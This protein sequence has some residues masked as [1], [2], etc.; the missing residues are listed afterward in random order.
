MRSRAASGS[1]D[2]MQTHRRKKV[3]IVVE[4]ARAPAVLERIEALGAKG[5]T[6]IPDVIGKGRHGLR[7]SSEVLDVNRS[8]L[9]IAIAGEETAAR[10]VE[11]SQA[12]LRNYTGVIWVSD[13]DVVRGDHF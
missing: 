3:E 5:Y 2:G 6:M 7:G 10:I 8:V 11:E 12:L 9:I 4:R 1:G 13:V